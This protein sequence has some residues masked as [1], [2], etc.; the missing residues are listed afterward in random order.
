MF[1]RREHPQQLTFD[2]RIG[3]AQKAGFSAEK[4][5][6]GRVR[7]SK[8]GCAAIVEDVPGPRPLVERA[9]ILIGDEIG[10]LVH[11]GYQ[12]F[13]LTPSGR[14]LPA[15][16]RHL[17]VLHAFQEDLR[18]ALGLVSLYNES[19]G[20]VN[21]SHMYDRLEDRDRGGRPRPW[22]QRIVS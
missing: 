16:A 9:G 5:P 7:L 22:E 21:D 13:L 8:D 19:L 12:E 20:T 4:Q 6:D 11:G 3:R 18:E 2:E 15:L 1:F 10:K 14:K 17:R